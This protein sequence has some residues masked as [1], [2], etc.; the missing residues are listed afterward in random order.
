MCVFWRAWA[1]LKT[2]FE[3]GKRPTLDAFIAERALRSG[4]SQAVSHAPQLYSAGVLALPGRVIG[5][6]RCALTWERLRLSSVRTTRNEELWTTTLVLIEY[7]RV[8]EVVDERG[9]ALSTN[10]NRKRSGRAAA[11]VYS[12][13]RRYSPGC[14]HSSRR[15]ACRNRTCSTLCPDERGQS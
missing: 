3:E 7:G 13:E 5:R 15:K 6:R 11:D 12:K 9:L 14:S 2:G 1:I 8:L 10:K 4:S